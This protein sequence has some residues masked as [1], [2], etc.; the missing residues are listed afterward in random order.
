MMLACARLAKRGKTRGFI[1]TGTAAGRQAHRQAGEPVC[2]DCRAAWAYERRLE[3]QASSDD[4]K[5][6]RR[7]LAAEWRIANAERHRSL[8]RRWAEANPDRVRRNSTR[9]KAANRERLNALARARRKVD[10]AVT[11]ER[12]RGF[13]QRWRAANPNKARA[14]SQRKRARKVG[15]LTDE[16]APLPAGLPICACCGT[17]NDLT[18]DHIKPL[19][20]GGKHATSNLQWLCR[21]CN[22][23]KNTHAHCRLEHQPTTERHQ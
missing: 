13:A 15:A 19:A 4:L 7:D 1:L 12:E 9:W 10:P 22:S 5:Q 11:R 23:S 3:W 20:R 16:H 21:S 2:D 6:H 14:Q 8:A 17:T 18:I